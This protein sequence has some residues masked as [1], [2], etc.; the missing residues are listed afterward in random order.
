MDVRTNGG[1]PAP[2][3]ASGAAPEA[4]CP[5]CGGS[6]WELADDGRAGTAR[7]CDCQDRERLP[8]LLDAAQVPPRYRSCRLESFNPGNQDALIK[9][10]RATRDW[11]EGVQG[12]DGKT[13]ENGL[14]F[15]GPT[16]VGKTHLACAALLESV[17]RWGLRGRFV[18]F[19]AL[20]HEI[21]S[22]FD[23]SSEESKHEVLAPVMN[24]DLLVV[25]ELGAQQPTAWV[26]DVLYLLLNHRYSRRLPTIFTTNC[27][28]ERRGTRG[29]VNLDA[30]RISR[31]L[32]EERVQAT[33]VS[34][35]YEMAVPVIMEAADH[36]REVRAHGLRAR[37]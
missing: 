28:L 21:Q 29:E 15:A 5:R 1:V 24:A 35:L 14:L 2:A 11:V 27:S 8:R 32:L 3:P 6:G 37:P 18:D 34:R 23:P 22:T 36:R 12:E 4:S 26:S 19:T 31:P 33:L 17:R 20:I 9:A 16:G 30:A 7:P 13:I 10:L 25:D